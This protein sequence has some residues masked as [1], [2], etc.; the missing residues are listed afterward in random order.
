MNEIYTCSRCGAKMHGFLPDVCPRCGA[1]LQTKTEPTR[2]CPEC[3]SQVV[4]C[5]GCVKCYVCGWSACGG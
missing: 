3:G 4:M 1:R 2:P 5:E